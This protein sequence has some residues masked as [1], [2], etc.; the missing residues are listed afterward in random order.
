VLEIVK[1]TVGSSVRI[2]K[3]SVRTLWRNR[4]PPR[5]KKRLLAA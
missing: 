5:W 1:W 3:M 2:K 4:P